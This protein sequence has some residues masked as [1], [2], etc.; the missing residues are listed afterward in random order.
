MNDSNL[1]ALRTL[2]ER[3]VRPVRVPGVLKMK[4]RE[5]LLAHVTAVFEQE[6]ASDSDESLAIART[7]ERFGDP[8]ALTSQL[9][10][11]LSRWQVVWGYVEKWFSYS[12][13]EFQPRAAAR[14]AFGASAMTAVVML[15]AFAVVKVVAPNPEHANPAFAF[16]PYAFVAGTSLF[17]GGYL[18]L[19]LW[20]HGAL[21]HRHWLKAGGIAVL[22]GLLVP[23]IT[24]AVQISVNGAPHTS[25]H[26]A[27]GLL[28]LSL[29]LT[30]L[31]VLGVSWKFAQELRGWRE[32]ATLSIE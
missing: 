11:S 19:G 28:P 16:E 32:W 20:M 31:A 22:S 4:M 24:F 25:L 10:A 26:T 13:I 8:R 27:I 12:P 14:Y 5:E 21:T 3:A 15:I 7:A 29:L 17:G 30:P 23:T 2:V 6:L 18:F 9:Q 1:I